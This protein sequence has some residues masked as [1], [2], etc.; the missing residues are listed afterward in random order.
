MTWQEELIQTA[1]D[2]QLAKVLIRVIEELLKNDHKLLE[3][4]VQERTI[5]HQL[6]SYMRP[7]FPDWHVDC[8]YNRKGLDPKTLKI[9]GRKQRKDGSGSLVQPDI[10]VH[11]RTKIY[12]NFLV[13][14][15]K[16]STNDSPDRDDEDKLRAFLS[17][18]KY[19]HGLFLRI[20]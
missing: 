16:K 13:I 7:F 19:E 20:G 18:L 4:D 3:V 9:P 1:K 15:I 8:E 17:E 14:E 2:Q 6:A 11:H 10:I 5:S 12:D